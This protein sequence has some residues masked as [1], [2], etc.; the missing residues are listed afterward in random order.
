MPKLGMLSVN[1]AHPFICFPF[2]FFSFLNY[3]TS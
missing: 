3:F 1:F 2:C